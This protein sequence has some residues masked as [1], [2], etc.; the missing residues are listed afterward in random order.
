MISIPLYYKLKSERLPLKGIDMGRK[1]QMYISLT[2]EKSHKVTIPLGQGSFSIGTKGVSKGNYDVWVE[3]DNSINWDAFN[4]FF[5]GYGQNNKEVYP[6][7]DWPRFFY[8]SGNDQGFIEWS[9]KRKIEEFQ[10]F[11]QTDVTVDLTKADIRELSVHTEKYIVQISTGDKLKSLILSGCLEKIVL[12]ECTEIPKLSFCL[13]CPQTENVSYQLPAYKVLERATSV[14][15]NNSPIGTAFD[16][17]SLLQFPNLINLNLTGN[18]INL[19]AL[20]KLINLERIGLRFIPELQDMPELISW[21]NLSSFIGYNIEETAG[22]ALR[23]ELNQ[24]LKEK[25]M[26]FSGITKLRKKKWFI[27]EY[28]IPFSGWEDKNAKI[29]TK[30]YKVCLNEIKKSK[31]ENELQEA[32]IKFI[33]TVNKLQGIETSEREDV[34]TAIEQLAEASPIEIPQEKW[35]V[36]FDEIREF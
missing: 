11:P 17:T 21:N 35:Q 7:G 33:K 15:I 34:G 18:M 16:C 23:A 8:Y 19:S 4:E 31:T 24:L 2:G 10:W 26:N 13:N 5:T 6:Y 1:E 29:A 25:A 9:F 12:K 36:W 3:K 22:K 28:G 30:A 20:A 14:D 27:T 32:I